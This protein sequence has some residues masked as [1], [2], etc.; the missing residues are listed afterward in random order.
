MHN[1]NEH[2]VLRDLVEMS[3]YLGDP[4]R[5]Y[6]ILGEGNTSARITE[7][8][9][10]VKAS[11]LRLQGI[12]EEGFLPVRSRDVLAML[13]EGDLDDVVV[14]RRLRAAVLREGETRK[15]SVETLLHAVLL[16]YPGC[17]FVGHAHPVA[18]NALLCSV[19]AEEA[20]AGRL[21]PDHI[22]VM[23]R[24]SLLIP[25][26]DP[27]L[28]LARCLRERLKAFIDAEG[29]LPKCIL[30]QNHGVITLG[31]TAQNVLNIMDMTEKM[32]HILLGAY[33]AGGPRFLSER[34]IDRIAT[35]PDEHYRQKALGLR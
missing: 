35:R 21:C 3:R 23:G 19:R 24:K 28:S 32:S 4:S 7:E 6:A 20:L 12:T 34:D 22:V 17:R 13:D 9:F 10:Y 8:Y 27:G 16:Q 11:G 30:L 33:A 2:A 14:E 29:E 15:P 1:E 25:Y 31:E 18:T 26:V 5:P